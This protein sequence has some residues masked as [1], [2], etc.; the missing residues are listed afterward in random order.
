MCTAAHLAPYQPGILQRLDVPGGGGQ[1]HGE[2]LRHLAP[3]CLAASQ[4]A[5]HPPAC[6]VAKSVKDRAQLRCLAEEID[7]ANAYAAN[8]KARSKSERE[9]YGMIT[10]A[11][12]RNDLFDPR[13]SIWAGGF[14]GSQTSDGNAALGS[15]AVTSRIAGP[16]V[17]ADYPFSPFT[18]TGFALAGRVTSF[19]IATTPRNR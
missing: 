19:A 18:I 7:S 17:G 16:A 12:P 6:G 2:R 11:P 4:V 14:G 10:K 1:R 15:N 3:R 5:E 9:A 8:G 13:W